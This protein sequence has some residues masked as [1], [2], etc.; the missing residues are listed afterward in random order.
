MNRISFSKL[1]A[2]PVRQYRK[3]MRR[4]GF[5]RKRVKWDVSYPKTWIWIG[6][7]GRLYYWEFEAMAAAIR[8]RNRTK[9]YNTKV[10]Q[11]G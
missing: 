3:F 1:S 2:K 11:G 4:F 9:K 7:T 5:S 8:R 10:V 6:P